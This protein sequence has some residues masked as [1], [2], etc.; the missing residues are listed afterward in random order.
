M[1]SKRRKLI[2]AVVPAAMLLGA[3]QVDT[4]MN[5]TEDETLTAVMNITDD[6]GLAAGMTCSDVEDNL[7]GEFPYADEFS[8]EGVGSDPLTCRFTA[9]FD[10]TMYDMAVSKSGDSYTVDIPEDFWSSFNESAQIEQFGTIDSTFTIEF[11]GE[12]TDASNGGQMNGNSVTWNDYDTLSQ[13]VSATGGAGGGG[14]DTTTTE[15]APAP[16]S[17]APTD[18]TAPTEDAAPADAD[19]DSGIP[20][21][22]WILIG[23]GVVGVIVAVVIAMRS[24]N[25]G[26]A[27]EGDPRVPGGYV[28]DGRTPYGAPASPAQGGVPYAQPTQFQQPGQPPQQFGHPEAGGQEPLQYG[29]SPQQGQPPQQGETDQQGDSGQYPNPPQS[30]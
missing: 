11:P 3:C 23:V 22:V 4:T 8:V 14:G 15:P 1:I 24:R 16:T 9:T 7:G 30:N 21:W 25:K 29:Q 13:G 20:V 12:V 27:G 5:V 10:Q 28:P 26:G 2:L 6:E 18:I 17:H 19:E